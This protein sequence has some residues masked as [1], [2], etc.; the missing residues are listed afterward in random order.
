MCLVNSAQIRQ[1]RPDSGLGPNEFSAEVFKSFLVVPLFGLRGSGFRFRDS[2]FRFRVSGFGFRVSGFGF[3]VSSLAFRV[4]CFVFWCL[5]C[6]FGFRV[7]W[8]GFRGSGAH[9][10]A[11]VAEGHGREELPHQRP[12]LI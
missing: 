10:A 9:D 7:S 8:F 1:S 3:R 2:G 11:L 5:A 12:H 6:Y 4:S